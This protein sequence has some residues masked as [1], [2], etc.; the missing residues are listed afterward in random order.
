M[1][2]PEPGV[3]PPDEQAL[4]SMSGLYEVER[5]ATY[6]SDVDRWRIRQEK[7]S[8]IIAKLRGWMRM[9]DAGQA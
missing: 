1:M 5:Q 7:T 8:P 2:A 6:M 9:P 4:I 3:S